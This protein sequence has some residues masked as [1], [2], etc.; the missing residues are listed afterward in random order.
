MING[1]AAVPIM[2]VMMLMTTNKK[3]VGG[4]RLPAPQKIVGWITTLV[5]LVVAISMIV[6]F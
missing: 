4:L 1:V 5:M 6:T 3:V 2:V